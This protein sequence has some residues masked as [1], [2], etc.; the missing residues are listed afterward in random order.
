MYQGMKLL[1]VVD[2]RFPPGQWKSLDTILIA[3]K[4]IAADVRLD[5]VVMSSTYAKVE[6]ALTREHFMAA[7]KPSS[8]IAYLP[9]DEFSPAVTSIFLTMADADLDFSFG[10]DP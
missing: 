7:G 2:Y 5:G 1:L 9:N 3:A 4:A 10:E 6:E 8:V